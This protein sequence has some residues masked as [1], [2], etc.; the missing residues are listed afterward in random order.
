LCCAEE[1]GEYERIW[2]TYLYRTSLEFQSK[3]K[4]DSGRVNAHLMTPN[5][6]LQYQSETGRS[7]IRHR[8]PSDA[9][10]WNQITFYGSTIP[11]TD[12]TDYTERIGGGVRCD[13][14]EA[15]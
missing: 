11:L 5:S 2:L 7:A 12:T 14:E 9:L 8:G 4:I 13:V 10:T 6:D 1:Q 15:K 3:G